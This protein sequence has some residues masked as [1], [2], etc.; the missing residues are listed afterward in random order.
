MLRMF[1]L[2]EGEKTELGWG[3]QDETGGNVNR[4]EIL[5]PYLGVLSSFRDDVRHLAIGKGDTALKDILALC[6][7]LRD[8]DLVPLGVALDDQED[9]KALVKLVSPAQLM[10]VREEK[11][12]ILEEKAAKKAAAIAAEQQKRQ[13]KIEK[14]RV[15]PKDMFKPPNVS[16]GKYS[17]WD[18]LG[19]PLTDGEGKELSKNQAKKVQKDHTDQAK[20]H[21]EFLAWHRQKDGN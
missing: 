3:Q 8:S 16:Q 14:G 17:S 11:R 20:L 5:M 6:D 10:K 13:Q 9:G 19:I 18:E 15:S 21:E 7:K 12:A 2:G 1:G 4:E